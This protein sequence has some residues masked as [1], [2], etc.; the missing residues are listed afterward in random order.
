[1]RGITWAVLVWTA[2]G[3]AGAGALDAASHA[4]GT[5]GHPA[6][7][8]LPAWG[9]FEIWAIGFVL[10]GAIWNQA[11]TGV[12]TT[13]D[14]AGFEERPVRWM[15]WIVLAWTVLWIVL[16]GTW[17]LNPAGTT[18]GE[19]P[20]GRGAP[21]ALKPPDWALFDLWA[22]GFLML[23]MIWLVTR[24]WSTRRRKRSSR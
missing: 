21:V 17:A 19:G 23:G 9:L 4:A 24:W 10:L 7:L 20:P 2:L 1:M 15:T 11:P 5:P 6:G 12:T 16:V 22:I 8:T 14:R 3:I 13:E 18:V